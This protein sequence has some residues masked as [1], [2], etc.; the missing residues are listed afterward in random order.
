MQQISFVLVHLGD[1]I[2]P[3]HIYYCINQIRA[4]NKKE[5]LI[6]IVDAGNEKYLKTILRMERCEI[7]SIDNLHRTEHHDHFR[8]QNRLF[9]E[10]MNG[11]WQY[12]TERLFVVEE[13]MSRFSLQNVVHLENDVMIYA[14]ADSFGKTL[15]SSY[16]GLGLTQDCDKRAI[17]GFVFIKN[18]AALREL[19]EMIAYSRE[20]KNDM[21]FLCDYINR[22]RESQIVNL[23][24]M[25]PSYLSRHQLKNLKGAGPA[26][27]D[28]YWQEYE[29]FGCIFDAASVGQFVGGIDKRHQ[30]SDTAGFINETA[31]FTPRDMRVAWE[32]I[33]GKLVPY[34][35]DG[36][37]K[38]PLANLH[39]HS[40]ELA[41]YSSRRS[42]RHILIRIAVLASKTMRFAAR[43]PVKAYQKLLRIL[44]KAICRYGIRPG[45][46]PYISGDSFR[47]IA[48]HIYDETTSMRPDLVEGGDTVFVKGDL[49]KRFFVDIHPSIR[50]HYVLITHNSDENITDRYLENI[51]DKIIRWFT[52]NL[53]CHHEK[54]EALPIGLENIMHARNG[55]PWEFRM[56]SFHGKK[57]DTKKPKILMSFSLSNNS[58]ERKEIFALLK[59]NPLVEIHSFSNPI[60][61]KKA[62]SRYMFVVSPPGNGFDCHRAWEAMYL[63]VVPIMK[64][65][66][67]N[68]QVR[69]P[70]LCIDKWGQ[71]NE[72]TPIDL[73]REYFSIFRENESYPGIYMNYWEQRIQN[74]ARKV[75]RNR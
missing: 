64:R 72:L 21:E 5:R 35:L 6:L 24:V 39:I 11:F 48:R 15:I 17:G 10:G 47:K 40:K 2:V 33:E 57:P 30:K 63:G 32:R 54:L 67:I 62:L 36:T 7:V 59:N 42:F 69:L 23:P 74:A 9:E 68:D 45:S 46:A 37:V 22:K 12:S 41:K 8:S 26:R 55:L 18:V 75:E 70:A 53:M 31:Y 61:Y 3:E 50:N 4:F 66:V 25:Y 71:V 51:D 49:L 16:S 28:F 34:I 1:G 20:K 60:E 65:S 19:T 56:F 44:K 43:L 27:A 29:S 52:Q 58:A 73:E 13:V 38:I 14:S